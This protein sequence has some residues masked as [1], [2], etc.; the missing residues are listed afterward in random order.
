[1]EGQG[2]AEELDPEQRALAQ[3]A[4]ATLAEDLGV[5][6]E[7][8][9]VDTIRP[10]QWRDSSLGCPQPGQQ[11][12]QVVTPGHRISLRMD[13]QLYT[14]HEAGGKAF[15][16]R[17]RKLGGVPL[18]PE[19]EIV[20]GEQMLEARADLASRLGVA[21]ND[22]RPV[23]GRPETWDDSSLGCPEPGKSYRPG[24]VQ[25]YVLVLRH[26][27]RQFTYHT[28]M[29]RTIPCPPISAD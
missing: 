19:L 28:D 3:L 4:I 17:Q 24:P 6:A 29:E 20:W 23:G 18:T 14:V 26:G 8:I 16:C 15:V 27:M 21:E 1:M 25:G 12:L 22:I 7:R 9:R 2:S 10:V 13:G 5:S 11:Y